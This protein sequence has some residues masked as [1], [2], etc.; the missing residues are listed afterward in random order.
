MD[1]IKDIRGMT[2]WTRAV[3]IPG[4]DEC[5]CA[6]DHDGWCEEWVRVISFLP[7]STD[8]PLML[9]LVRKDD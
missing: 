5:P 2:S 9:C 6:C 7:A 8:Y 1:W 3:L 4:E